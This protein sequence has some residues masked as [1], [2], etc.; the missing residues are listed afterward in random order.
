MHYIGYDRWLERKYRGMGNE[1]SSML[2]FPL[3]HL[4]LFILVI[5]LLKRFWM[6]VWKRE[7]DA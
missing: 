4:P 3:L 7:E 6:I 1:R 5:S 2:V